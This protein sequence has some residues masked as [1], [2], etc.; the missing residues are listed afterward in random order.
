MTEIEEDMTGDFRVQDETERPKHGEQYEKDDG[1]NLSRSVVRPSMT[2][3]GEDTSYPIAI[4]QIAKP[5][6]RPREII[7]KLDHDSTSH[8]HDKP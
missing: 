3:S 2:N 4:P 8:T 1:K 7:E 5:V 6:C